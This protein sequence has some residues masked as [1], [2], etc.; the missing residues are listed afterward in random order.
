MLKKQTIKEIKRILSETESEN[1]YVQ[2]LRFDS[3][4]GVQKALAQWDKNQEQKIRLKEIFDQQNV[5]ELKAKNKGYSLVA[6]VD[7]VGRGPLAGPVVCA[8]VILDPNQPILGLKDSKKI[9]EK[10]RLELYEEINHKALAVSLSQASPE[11]I[12]NLNIL[13]ATQQTM[14]RAVEGLSHQ[15]DY[16]LVDAMTLNVGISQES[17][18][19]GD[20]KSNS[21][22]AA[23]IIAKVTRDELMKTYAKDYPEYE[24]E[25]NMG[26]GTQGHL[27]ALKEHGPCP[28][29]RRSFQPIKSMVEDNIQQNSLF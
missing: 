5:Y 12:D 23:S 24:F 11:E 6:G 21:I 25:S 3:R 17:L 26:Y 15:P 9:S 7:E 22:A 18:I 20:M 4:S 19:K 29:H 28:I 13:A 8:A 1:D 2:S 14:K 10:K 16:L 27:S